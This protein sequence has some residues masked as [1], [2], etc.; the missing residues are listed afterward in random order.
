M[1]IRCTAISALFAVLGVF[2]TAAQAHPD[3]ATA[4]PAAAAAPQPADVKALD[5]HTREDIERHQG[6]ARAH[7]EAAQCLASGRK[8]D[9]CTKQ[10]Q[11]SCKG[12]ALGKNCG[13][14]HSH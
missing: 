9:D 10:L 5:A 7:S 3:P 4:Q 14:R 11:A 8:S 6:M 2:A 13:M 1:T 12:L